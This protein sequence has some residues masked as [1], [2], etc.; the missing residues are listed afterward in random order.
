M[1]ILLTGAAGQLGMEFQ[2]FFEENGVEYI[3][4]ARRKNGKYLYLDIT[5]FDRVIDVVKEHKPDVIINCAAYNKVDQAEKDWEE[6]YRVNGLGVRNLAQAAD[7]VKTFLVHYSTNYVF[8]GTKKEGYTIYDEPRPINKYGESKH[9]GE[10][11]LAMFYNDYALI[12]VSWVFGKYGEN[13]I[14]KLLRWAKEKDEIRLATD[15]ISSPTYTGDIV[16]FTWEIVKKRMRGLYHLSSEGQ[17]S[18][19]ELGKY[20]LEIIG[21]KGKII[22]AKQENFNLPARRPMWGKLVGNQFAIFP[23]HWQVSVKEFFLRG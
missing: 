5:D 3:P 13:F 6:A 1:K 9:L 15:E 16:R 11:M 8:D 12:R 17:C 10:K 19:Y 21:W 14:T 22:P 2:K 7:M 23:A 20:V 18:R 4:A